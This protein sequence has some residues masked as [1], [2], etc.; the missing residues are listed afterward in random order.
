MTKN[1]QSFVL[2]CDMAQHLQLL[3]DEQA[4]R[5]FKALFAYVNSGQAPALDDDA[6]RMA[7]SFISSQI[8]RDA[9]KWDEVR[10]KRSEAGKQGGRPKST[11]KQSEAEKA[12]AFFA[13]QTKSKKADT[14]T[15]TD[16]ANIFGADSPPQPKQKRFIPPTVDV[17]AAYCWEI[18]AGIDP[19]AFVDYYSANGWV[20]GK[21]KPIKDWK[22]AVRNWARNTRQAQPQQSRKERWERDL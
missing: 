16:T 22:A 6:V 11:E 8:D 20:Q 17:V 18:G 2:Y 10:R 1:K 3:S 7:F 13:N 14:V 15:G 5:L 9:A 21:G 19:N 12:F 4:G